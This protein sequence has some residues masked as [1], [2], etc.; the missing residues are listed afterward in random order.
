MNWKNLVKLLPMLCFSTFI[1]ANTQQISAQALLE[2]LNTGQ[3]PLILDVRSEAEF[4]QGH[5]NTAMNISYEQLETKSD[6]LVAY[7][8]KPIVIYCRSGRRAQ[9]AYQ[10]LKA[11]GFTQLIDLQGHMIEWEKRR[12]PL[13]Y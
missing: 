6:L 9:V 13:V 2:L 4:Q 1:S 5:I 7:K 8:H 12:Y 10:T 3:A 11:K